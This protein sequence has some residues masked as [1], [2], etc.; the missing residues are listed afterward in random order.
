MALQVCY[1]CLNPLIT[2]KLEAY[3]Y[4][5]DLLAEQI[6]PT[7][8]GQWLTFRKIAK[9]AWKQNR[10]SENGISPGKAIEEK[11]PSI[12][13]KEKSIFKSPFQ[14]LTVEKTN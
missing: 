3:R 2:K 5:L 6:L 9:T 7:K 12:V 1:L 4:H 13:Y 10:E 14:S 8:L 11:E